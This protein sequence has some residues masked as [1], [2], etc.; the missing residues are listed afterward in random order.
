MVANN[1]DRF[2]GR[3][4][5]ILNGY[6]LSLKLGCN[7]VFYWPNDHRFPEM[8]EQ[9]NFFSQE[10]INNHR[11]GT[12]PA[13]EEIH[14]INFNSF[15]SIEGMRFINHTDGLAYFK[16]HDFFSLPKFT[17]E[18]ESHAREFY[19][20]TA[21]SVMSPVVKLLWEKLRQSYSGI[22]AIHGRYGD[23]VNGS[24][25]Q[26]VDTGKY[27]DTLSIKTLVEKLVKGNK[28]VVILSD[29]PEISRALEKIM[30]IK[31]IPV[32]SRASKTRNI[33]YFELQTIELFILALSENIYA[34]SH[35]AFSI[36]A[37][38]LGNVPIK[39]IRQET[40]DILVS[41]PKGHLRRRFYSKFDRRV[42]MQIKSRDLLSV[43]QFYWKS[44]DFDVVISLIHDAHESDNEYVY[45]LCLEALI[46]KIDKNSKRSLI[47]VKKAESLART[48]INIHHDPLV[49]TLLVKWCLLKND[50]LKETEEIKKEISDLYPYQFSKQNVSDFIV[51][52]ETL[53]FEI[54]LASQTQTSNIGIWNEIVNSE[55]NELIYGLLT[56]LQKKELLINSS[57]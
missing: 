41:M 36:L 14:L 19:A 28:Q 7:F 27:I 33:T 11:I 34:P 37:S 8:E 25:C 38:R 52:S 6:V 57:K 46:A 47:L 17:D 18:D 53:K 3:V 12:C 30:H 26:Y 39:S 48:R 9:V 21:K 4:L 29:T 5:D 50:S 35:S 16:D 15:D 49:L 10:F 2:G 32:E 24:F 51:K 40:G 22:E 43:L 20:E 31:L 13:V 56:F 54:N 55:E 45:S 44:L 23:L 42:R 1:W